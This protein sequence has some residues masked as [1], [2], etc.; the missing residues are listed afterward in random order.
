MFPI[1]FKIDEENQKLLSD[2]HRKKWRSS[3]NEEIFG[4][5]HNFSFRSRTKYAFK[6]PI[7]FIQNLFI[8]H[9]MV[10]ELIKAWYI[11]NQCKHKY[12]TNSKYLF[13]NIYR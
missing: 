7:E 12:P 5:F 2:Y 1:I 9:K 6:H 3:Y 4:S 13:Y 8:K 11:H 10:F